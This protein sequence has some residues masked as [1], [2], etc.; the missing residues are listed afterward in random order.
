MSFLSALTESLSIHC[1]RRMRH[2]TK[3]VHFLP[4]R[5]GSEVGSGGRKR[6]SGSQ[7]G[8]TGR[9]D[10]DHTSSCLLQLYASRF[11]LS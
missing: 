9:G 10:R 8:D 1:L 4:P 2:F 3:R 5:E 11:L 6:H 7:N